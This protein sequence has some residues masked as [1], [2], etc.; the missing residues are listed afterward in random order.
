MHLFHVFEKK[1]EEVNKIMNYLYVHEKTA[2]PQNR[3]PFLS[4]SFVG[5]DLVNGRIAP[6]NRG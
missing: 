3:I 6:A 4:Y 5:F 1:K 2:E